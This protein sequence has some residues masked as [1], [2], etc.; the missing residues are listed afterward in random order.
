[1]RTHVSAST[2]SFLRRGAAW[3]SYRMNADISFPG[4]PRYGNIFLSLRL[5]R[6]VA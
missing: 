3:G 2:G 1:M 6:R 4:A 5:V